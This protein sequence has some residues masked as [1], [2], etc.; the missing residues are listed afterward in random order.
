MMF[1]LP[2]TTFIAATGIPIA[3]GIVL[4]IWGMLY[5]PEEDE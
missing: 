5:K 2:D 4:L 3:I 1:G